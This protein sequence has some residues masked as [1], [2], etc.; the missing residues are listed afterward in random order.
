MFL[1]TSLEDECDRVFDEENET[2][3]EIKKIESS[4]LKQVSFWE[5]NALI[6]EEVYER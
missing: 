6:F 5:D 4:S 3:L 2:Y 1:A